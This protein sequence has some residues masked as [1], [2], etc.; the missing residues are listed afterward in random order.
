MNAHYPHLFEPLKV[1]QQTL[2]NRLVMGSMHTG[3]EDRFFSLKQLA[4]FYEERAAGGVGLII[5][6]GF[7]PHWRGWLVPFSSMLTKPWQI[8]KHR[9]VTESVH[10]HGAKIAL[11][12]LHAGRY[13]YHP[14]SLGPTRAKSPIT[15]FQPR[16]MTE[17]Q[18]L[19][20]IRAFARTAV[21]AKK[22]GY[23][24]VE[25]MGSEGYLINEFLT[26]KTNTR[27]DRWGGS[28]ENRARL[29]VEIVKAVRQAVGEDFLIIYRLS[30]LEL[31]P[32]GN[33]LQENI[34][35]AKMIEKAGASILGTGIGWHEARVPTIATDVPRAAFTWVTE[36]IKK[37]VQI[38]VI[39]SNRINTPEV[40]EQILKQGQ[41]DLISMARPW[42]ADA[43]FGVKASEGKPQLIN[44]C[45]ACNQACLDHIFSRKNASCLVNPRA[46]YEMEFP[47]VTP[48]LKSRAEK[49]A[50]VGA[51]PSGMTA[52]CTLAARGYHVHL[53]D[54][55][56]QIGGQF[57][58]AKKVPGKE[59]FAETLRY[60][61]NQLK[62]LQ[63]EVHLGKT[64]S[65]QE[66]IQQ[67]F[68][69]VILA[70]GILPRTLN[71]EGFKEAEDRKQVV[72]YLQILKG[73]VPV[74]NRVAII[75]AGGIGFD[76]AKF[77]LHAM[78]ERSLKKS[79]VE[80][81]NGILEFEKEWGIGRQQDLVGGLQ[82][83]KPFRLQQGNDFE[84]FLM[85]RKDQSLGKNL[86]KTTGWIHRA[87]L[88]SAGVHMLSGV[89]YQKLS[90][91]GFLIQ[92]Q[93]QEKLL[94]VDQII[95]CA[96]QVSFDIL[97]KELQDLSAEMKSS[98]HP[99]VHVIGGARVALELD[100]KAAIR[101]GF[102][103]GSRI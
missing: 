17:G 61:E 90:E 82:D 65:A 87:A 94:A 46:G 21:L 31:V 86:G 35:V 75:G 10:K 14:F 43:D 83:P 57:H 6:G 52:A 26:M 101:D 58:L 62:E 98:S 18:I 19:S 16:A 5:T 68:S 56:T 22:A 13:G 45:I 89:Q 51:G 39:A 79:A 15:P 9:P 103:L 23:D 66:L 100:A 67:A 96:G 42:L 37:H 84:I 69:K 4:K 53:F 34:E 77:V 97:S 71:L 74:G 92:H 38:P 12:I 28:L 85:Q 55:Q 2:R 20:T 1:G 63:V 102:E 27:T 64:V 44:T 95:I 80:K 88:K 25:I 72:S 60:F 78:K 59:E 30:M 11:Q 99:E 8:F 93:G 29:A 73:E 54:Q 48:T 70:T 81:Q 32:R 76:V 24:G 3:L 36:E 49:I 41:S 91:Q 47:L 40:A 33:S 7:A 50:V